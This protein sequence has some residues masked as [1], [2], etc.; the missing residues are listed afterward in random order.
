M[1]ALPDSGLSIRAA[2][3]TQRT[4]IGVS[5]IAVSHFGIACRQAVFLGFV[6]FMM[7]APDLTEVEVRALRRR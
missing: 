2:R 3:W 1:G 4:S 6:Y 7:P 5:M